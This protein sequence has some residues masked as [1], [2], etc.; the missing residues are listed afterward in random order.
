MSYLLLAR[1]HWKL[2]GIGLLCLLLGIQTIRLG[3]ANNRA[4]RIQVNLNEARAELKRISTAKNEQKGETERRISQ[5]EK[6]QKGAETIAK[7]IE[8][9]PVAPNCATPLEI[10]GAD[11]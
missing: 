11:L 7:R 8:A 6:G 9:A 4:D 3:A 1:A 10:M 5:A 2:L